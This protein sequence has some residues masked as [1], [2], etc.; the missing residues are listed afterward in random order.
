MNCY[1]S[2]Q[3]RISQVLFSAESGLP[4]SQAFQ[5]KTS[6]VRNRHLGSCSKKFPNLI[7]FPCGFCFTRDEGQDT[8]SGRVIILV[9]SKQMIPPHTSVSLFIRNPVF[10]ETMGSHAQKDAP[11]I[12]LSS[13]YLKEPAPHKVRRKAGVLQ[14][15]AI[16]CFS[17]LP[18]GDSCL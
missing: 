12:H 14:R 10:L 9:Q 15:E 3:S 1:L 5:P 16:K 7:A 13:S 4:L 8:A 11:K 17:G 6:C 2:Y 18:D